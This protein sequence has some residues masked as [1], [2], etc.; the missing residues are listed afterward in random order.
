MTETLHLDDTARRALDAACG[1]VQDPAG[2]DEVDGVRPVVVVCPTSTE[3]VSAVMRA[4]HEHDLAVVVRGRGTKLGWGRAPRRLD[5]L[6]D[7]SAMDQVLEHASGDL[8]ASAQAGARLAD[9]QAVLGEAGQRLCIDET[10][11]GASI[12][13]TLASLASGPSRVAFGTMRDL[14]IGL[15]VVRADGVVAKAGGRVVKNVAGYD[16]GKLLGGSF[17]TLAVITEVLFRVHPVPPARR[18]VSMHVADADQ[19]AETTQAVLHSQS[20]PGALEVDW[21]A[22]GTG[23][24]TVLLE[25]NAEGVEG[26]TAAVLEILGDQA[27]AE[28]SAPGDW[29]TYPWDTTSRGDQRATALKATFALSAL[30][31][32]L[33]ATREVSVEVA[34]RGSAGAGVAYAAVPA[35]TAATEVAAAVETLR[36]VCVRHGGSLVVLDAA[37]EVKDAVD[38]WGPVAGLDLM[39]RVKDQFDPDHRLAPGRFVG[40]I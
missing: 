39:R 34:L 25:G 7:L 9:V 12:G 19:A 35:G 28:E 20:V 36:E 38:P 14:L 13:G 32:V 30:P 4:A 18:W 2:S 31:E 11:P 29:G 17:G 37:A 27:R 3:E 22:T 21:P 40:G 10:V 5:V 24:V 33:R 8:I 23:T 15:T 16:L 6:L 26:R 1:Q